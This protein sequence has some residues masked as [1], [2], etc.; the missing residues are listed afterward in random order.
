MHF[1][2][3]SKCP[4]LPQV[5]IIVTPY[6]VLSVKSVHWF[7]FI[8]ILPEDTAVSRAVLRLVWPFV[9]IVQ[10]HIHKRLI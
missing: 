7:T 4:Y 10:K 6:L 2:T 8:G 3:P 1:R 9:G 5:N